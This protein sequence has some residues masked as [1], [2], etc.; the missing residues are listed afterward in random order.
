[1]REVRISLSLI[2]VAPPLVWRYSNIKASTI[3]KLT[4]FIL[5]AGEICLLLV[6]IKE[7]IIHIL[8]TNVL[9]LLN[10]FILVIFLLESLYFRL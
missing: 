9:H 5:N 10:Y 6:P 4:V 8:I 1:L 2:W 3:D 7:G